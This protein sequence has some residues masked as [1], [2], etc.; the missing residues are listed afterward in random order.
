MLCPAIVRLVERDVADDALDV[1][2]TL[3]LALPVPELGVTVAHVEALEV[4][5]EQFDPLAMMPIDPEPPV[6]PK[7]LPSDAAFNVTLHGVGS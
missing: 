4:V 5:H 7:G 3:T 2:V 6:D 1:T